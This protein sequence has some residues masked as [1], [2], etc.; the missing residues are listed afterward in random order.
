MGGPAQ[1]EKQWYT[2]DSIILKKKILV[3]TL[4]ALTMYQTLFKI[5]CIY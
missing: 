3:N 2:K 4:I 1:K 5:N